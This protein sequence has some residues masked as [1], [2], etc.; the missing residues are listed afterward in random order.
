[1]SDT[2]DVLLKFAGVS[3]MALITVGTFR[4]V[5]DMCG[6]QGVEDVRKMREKLFRD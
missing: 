6:P 3:L 2:F 5:L 4:V 1:M